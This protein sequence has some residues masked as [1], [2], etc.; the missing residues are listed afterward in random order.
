MWTII[1]IGFVILLLILGFVA[2][3]F[4]DMSYFAMS[5]VMSEEQVNATVSA[6]TVTVPYVESTI[7]VIPII[8]FVII[9]FILIMM[10]ALVK[11]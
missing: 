4:P 8:P 2:L 9:G 3:I 1:I 5:A 10:F 7:N 11:R 6:T